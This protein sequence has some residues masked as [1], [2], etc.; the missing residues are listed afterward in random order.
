MFYGTLYRSAHDK[1]IIFLR[2][3]KILNLTPKPDFTVN[4]NL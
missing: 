1:G 2:A 4:F 3:V